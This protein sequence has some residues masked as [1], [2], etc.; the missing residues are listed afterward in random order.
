MHS[1]DERTG[2]GG[3]LGIS[4]AICTIYNLLYELFFQEEYFY[5]MNNLIINL[6][7]LIRVTVSI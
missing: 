3:G 7:D 2:G 5:T 4:G 6:I 1:Y